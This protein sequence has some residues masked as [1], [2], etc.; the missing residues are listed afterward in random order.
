MS[1]SLQEINQLSMNE[2]VR[3]GHPGNLHMWWNRSPIESSRQLLRDIITESIE[4]TR[5][6]DQ[7]KTE[8]VDKRINKNITIVDP[9]SGFGGLALAAIKECYQAKAGDLNSVATLLTKAVAEIPSMFVDQYPVSWEERNG[10]FTGAQGLAEDVRYYGNWIRS[11][12]ENSLKFIY[13]DSISAAD[14]SE[15]RVYAWIW[16][17]TVPCPNPACGC[18]MPMAGSYVLAKLKGREYYAQPEVKDHQVLFQVKKGLRK[19]AQSGNKIGNSGAKFRCPSCGE[20]TTDEYVKEMGKAGKLGNQLVAIGYESDSG[21][22]YESP[23]Q[24]HINAAGTEPPADLPLGDLP[25]NTRWFSPPLF[26]LTRYTDLYTSRQLHLMTTLC[27]LVDKAGR[28]VYEDAI[29]AGMQDDGVPL[30]DRGRGA[31]AYSQAVS[32]Y[33]SLVVGKIAN[34]QSEICTWDNRNGNIRAAFTRQA[35]PMTWVFAE[36][37][38]FSSVTGNFNTMLEDVVGAVKAM[39]CSRPAEVLQGNGIEFPFPENAVLF[40]ELPY[41]DNVGYADLSDYF[42][43]WLRR[44]LRDVY[45]DLFKNIVTAKEE[46]TSIPEHYGGDSIRARA[47][48]QE[49]ISRLFRNFSE[50]ADQTIPSLVFFEFGRNDELAMRSSDQT[51]MGQGTHNST[52]KEISAWENMIHSI[53]SAGFQVKAVLPVRAEKPSEKYESTRVCV[54]FQKRDDTAPQTTRRGFVSELKRELPARLQNIFVTG[55]DEWDYPIVGMGAGLSLFTKYKKIINADGSEMQTMDALRIIWT[56]TEEHI[57]DYVNN[58]AA[59]AGIK[60]L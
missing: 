12:L 23:S 42:Y 6:H 39:T 52:I 20:I 27:D 45:P 28:K 31:Y 5:A 49:E 40:T 19:E 7:E 36:G 41:Y 57:Q 21:R 10:T 26:G 37:N 30:S 43:I 17:R 32:V 18:T 15:K 54:V 56:E 25:D 11:E 50:A 3:K 24:E 16:T 58:S 29:K 33:L 46:L 13:P 14:I 1:M 4:L 51:V 38:P 47:A 34:F 35:I 55:I 59:E 2:R 8:N 53:H 48:Y 60:E 22:V 44:C 9:F